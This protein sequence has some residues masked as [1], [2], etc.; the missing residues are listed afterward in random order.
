MNCSDWQEKEIKCVYKVK[1]NML[2]LNMVKDKSSYY[3]ENNSNKLKT[4]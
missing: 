2:F 1:E 3:I 4:I